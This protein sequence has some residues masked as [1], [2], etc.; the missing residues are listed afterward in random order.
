METCP[1]HRPTS[2][3]H[4]PQKRFFA[5]GPRN[6]LSHRAARTLKNHRRR[7][8]GTLPDA[9]RQQWF[10]HRILDVGCGFG[11]QGWCYRH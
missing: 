7:L 6:P 8:G 3:P 9:R 2:W 4:Y 10:K 5:A 1:R 11:G